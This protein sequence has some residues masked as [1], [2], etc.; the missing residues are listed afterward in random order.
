MAAEVFATTASIDM[1]VGQ[2]VT[3]LAR[4]K[5]IVLD[6]P[7]ALGGTDQGMN[8]VEALLG[9]LGACKCIVA[10]SF[11]AAQGIRL[12]AIEI[13][14]EGTL[15]PDGFTGANPQ[16]KVGFSA[17]RTRYRIDADNTDAELDAFIEYIDGHC[18]VMDTIVNAPTFEHTIERVGVSRA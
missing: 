4:G 16:A 10:K 12:R 3:A 13:D 17:I 14:L 5:D 15:D 7:P 9:A 11:A 1:G 8:P 2:V 18:P 6:E